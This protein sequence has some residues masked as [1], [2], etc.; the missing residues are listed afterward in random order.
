MWSIVLAL[1]STWLK[2]VWSIVPA[3]HSTWSKGVWSIVLAS[4]MVEVTSVDELVITQ[5]SMIQ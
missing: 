2:G 4:D 5:Y 1:H 3:S